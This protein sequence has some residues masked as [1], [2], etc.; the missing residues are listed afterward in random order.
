MT[1]SNSYLDRQDFIGE[2]ITECIEPME[3]GCINKPILTI[4]FREWYATN[5]SGKPPNMR[6]IVDIMDKRFGKLIGG[7]WR[8][9]RFKNQSNSLHDGGDDGS[10]QTRS[11]QEAEGEF[12]DLEEI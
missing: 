2:F 8:G 9:I 10:I 7:M 1:S 5:F 6:D 11:V 4:R 3:T 12:V